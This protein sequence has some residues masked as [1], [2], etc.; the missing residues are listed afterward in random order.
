[1]PQ[2]KREQM[3]SDWADAAYAI[4]ARDHSDLLALDLRIENPARDFPDVQLDA[5]CELIVADWNKPAKA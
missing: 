5:L 3:E 2:P 1:M 4:F